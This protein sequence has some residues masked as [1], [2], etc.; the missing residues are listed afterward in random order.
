[1]TGRCIEM[2]KNNFRIEASELYK[3]I[4]SEHFLMPLALPELD[5]SWDIVENQSVLLREFN[6]E[7]L[8]NES[9][10]HGWYSWVHLRQKISL[11]IK[12]RFYTG[13]IELPVDKLGDNLFIALKKLGMEMATDEILEDFLV[14]LM[15]PSG[16]ECEDRFFY[17]LF[18][19]YQQGYWSCGWI[20]EYPCGKIRLFGVK[21]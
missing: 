2:D 8:A 7:F 3:L 10:N 16:N 6:E 19:A 17:T 13:D 14:F 5:V 21:K 18:S 4:H 9:P 20:G 15:L 12:E 11:P 1:M